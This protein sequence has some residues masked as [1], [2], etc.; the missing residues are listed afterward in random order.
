MLLCCLAF[1]FFYLKLNWVL[2]FCRMYLEFVAQTTGS[3]V[4]VFGAAAVNGTHD[5]QVL[6][7]IITVTII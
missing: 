4:A 2:M 7:D 1:E 3:D 5:K 6:L